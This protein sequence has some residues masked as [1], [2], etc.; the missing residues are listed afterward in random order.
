M[1]P[2]LAGDVHDEV[3]HDQDL[4]ACSHRSG[5]VVENITL[6]GRSESYVPGE[7]RAV[8]QNASCENGHAR[9]GSP[10]PGQGRKT[11]SFHIRERRVYS[12]RKGGGGRRYTYGRGATFFSVF[13][14]ARFLAYIAERNVNP[15]FTI[16][17]EPLLC[18]T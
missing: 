13:F 7:T 12:R 14:P 17:R 9:D 11:R 1:K 4:K 15:K 5:E 18:K 2:H 3:G 8:T 10:L 16:R 6:R